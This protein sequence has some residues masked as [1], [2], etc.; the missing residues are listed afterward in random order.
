[1]LGSTGTVEQPAHRSTNARARAGR[2]ERWLVAVIWLSALLLVSV[3]SASRAYAFSEPRSY[4]DGANHGGGGGRWFTSSPAEGFGCSVCHTGGGKPKLQIMGLP[5]DGYQPASTYEVTLAWPEFAERERALRAVP[6]VEPPS[7]GLIAELV[8]ES[9][10]G[11]GRLELIDS[12]L[13]PSEQCRVPGVSSSE[14]YQVRPGELAKQRP[15]LCD[16]ND[17]GQRCLLAVVSCGAAQVRFRW[18]TPQQSVGPVWF[19]AGFVTTDS[20]NG[21]P[22]GDGVLEVASPMLPAS[23]SAVRYES[24]LEGGCSIARGPGA[25]RANSRDAY[26]LIAIG[27]LGALVT[28]RRRSAAAKERA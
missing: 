1:M 17:L 10:Y 15:E 19:S 21:S 2:N 24:T 14:L 27:L 20:I 9:G 28:A 23:S 26:L 12:A 3:V 18:S 16:A 25:E 11:A 4:D 6:D 22:A 5:S 7:M 8:S 13:V